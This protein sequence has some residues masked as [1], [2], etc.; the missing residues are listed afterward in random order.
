[1]RYHVMVDIETWGTG[2]NAMPVSIGAAKFNNDTILDKF[3]VGIDPADFV[4]YGR[5][6][7]ASTIMWWM[8]EKQ[9]PALD[10]WLALPKVDLYS[11]VRGFADWCAIETPVFDTPD[12]KPTGQGVEMPVMVLE[13]ASL[14]GYGATFDNVILE[15]AAKACRI[16]WPFDHRSN[17]CFRTLRKRFPDVEHEFVGTAH[18]AVDD[19][20]NQALHLQKIAATHGI[21]L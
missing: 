4:Q 17:E 7:D 15:N 8:S 6:I 16:D 5:T 2:S 21:V 14:W 18:S 12:G 20:L 19:A 10:Y 1:M 9:R 11:A 3:E 13:L